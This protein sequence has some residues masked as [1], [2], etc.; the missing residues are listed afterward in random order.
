MFYLGQ[1]NADEV[2]NGQFRA[3]W[4]RTSPEQIN[5]LCRFPAGNCSI[6]DPVADDGGVGSRYSVARGHSC[7]TNCDR[8]HL[9]TQARLKGL[10]SSNIRN[11]R[12]FELSANNK[13]KIDLPRNDESYPDK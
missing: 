5:F 11:N 3:R 9:D 12:I 7:A 4:E 2:E 6:I 10:L 13:Y 1:C 8:K